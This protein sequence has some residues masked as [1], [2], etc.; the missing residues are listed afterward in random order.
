MKHSIETIEEWDVI[1]KDF[2]DAYK[3]R[4][5]HRHGTIEEWE[6]IAKEC[7]ADPHASRSECQAALNGITQSEDEW[8]R[9]QLTKKMEKAWKANIN[10]PK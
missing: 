6:I 4:M 1:A 2:A 5:K 3:H 9:E 10:A 8:R 7:I